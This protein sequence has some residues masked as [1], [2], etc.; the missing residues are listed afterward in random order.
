MGAFTKT[1]KRIA[2]TEWGWTSREVSECIHIRP[3]GGIYGQIWPEPEGVSEGA[4]Q[5]N[6]QRL[7]SHFSK[8]PESSHNTDI[9]SFLTMILQ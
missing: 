8:Y 4:H 1:I 5:G 7:S 6:S 2:E 9:I 3:R